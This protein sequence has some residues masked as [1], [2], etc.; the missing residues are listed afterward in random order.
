MQL[1]EG[2]VQLRIEVEECPGYLWFRFL[3][4]YHFGDFQR[5][6]VEVRRCCEEKSVGKA[7]ADITALQGEIPDF[8][9]YD[10]GVRFAEVFGPVIK[11]AG[12]TPQKKS[13]RFMENTAVNRQ[14]RLQAFSD[15]QQAL[16]WLLSR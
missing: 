11:V 3:G 4:T 14:A 5:A 15:R 8:D 1:T 6:M 7:L 16:D 2:F 9:R 10:L 12:L 13:N